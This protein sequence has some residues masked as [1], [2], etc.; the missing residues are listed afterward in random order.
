MN[1]GGRWL[2]LA[3]VGSTQDVARGLIEAGDKGSVVFAEDQTAGRGRFDRRWISRPGESL[4]LSLLL[5][6]EAEHPCPH[7]LGMAVAIGAAEAFDLRLRWPNDLLLAGRKVGGVLAELVKDPLG[8]LVPVVGIGINLAQ[9]EFPAEIAD[10]ATSLALA[11]RD[12]PD[13]RSAATQLVETLG[14][15]PPVTDW[16]SLQPRWAIRDETA[17]LEYQL[18]NGQ[19]GLALGIGDDA[20]LLVAIGGQTVEVLAAEAW[21]GG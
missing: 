16:A 13:P 2:E 12:A 9:T 17:G 8:R 1:L 14:A 5:W 18:P 7:L 19:R 4:T 3:S 10:R 21:L 15:L 20:R 6:G 11:G